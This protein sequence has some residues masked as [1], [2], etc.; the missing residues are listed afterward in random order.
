MVKYNKRQKKSTSTHAQI[1]LCKF[2]L[3]LKGYTINKLTH[4]H[5]QNNEQ[6]NLSYPYHQFN[7][8]CDQATTTEYRES[9]NY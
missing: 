7:Q 5:S 1:F 9:V 4:K 6:F 3:G 8:L 2:D